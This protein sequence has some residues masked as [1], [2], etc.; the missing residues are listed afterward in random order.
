M[1]LASLVVLVVM[2]LL[3]M[4]LYSTVFALVTIIVSHHWFIAASPLLFLFFFRQKLM[5]GC[6][7][8]VSTGVEGYVINNADQTWCMEWYFGWLSLDASFFVDGMK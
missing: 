6:D 8:E 1:L 7:V 3:T 4:V 5:S 2:S